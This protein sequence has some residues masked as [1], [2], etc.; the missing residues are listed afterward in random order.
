[1]EQKKGKAKRPRRQ[2]PPTT[3]ASVPPPG[4]S[5]TSEIDDM[6]APL[7]D[8]SPHLKDYYAMQEQ[9]RLLHEELSKLNIDVQDIFDTAPSP[10]AFNSDVQE[11][12]RL[13]I[14]TVESLK[15][16][17][18]DRSLVDTLSRDLDDADRSSN[19]SFISGNVYLRH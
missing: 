11:Q 3:P 19:A 14:A 17:K 1:M 8:V 5:S 15:L 13:F 12:E 9:E 16:N 10:S 2:P 4:V 7:P 18:N 6:P